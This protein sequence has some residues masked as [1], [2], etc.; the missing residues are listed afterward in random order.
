M[1]SQETLDQYA[2]LYVRLRA[3]ALPILLERLHEHGVSEFDAEAIRVLVNLPHPYE[4]DAGEMLQV[5]LE[6]TGGSLEFACN[7]Q[8]I[9]QLAHDLQRVLREERFSGQSLPPE[10]DILDT[11]SIIASNHSMLRSLCLQVGRLAAKSDIDLKGQCPHCS[12]PLVEVL[13]PA[14]SGMR[15]L[16]LRCRDQTKADCRNTEWHIQDVAEK[17][18]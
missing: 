7:T 18:P 10:M 1:I 5:A 2:K 13:V 3:L 11:R 14:G 8:G 16:R 15:E 6:C 12:G 17:T 4:A 9:G